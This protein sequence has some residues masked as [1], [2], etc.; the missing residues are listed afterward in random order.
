MA[1]I[2]FRAAPGEAAFPPAETAP[3]DLPD[4][5]HLPRL[6]DT[7]VSARAAVAAVAAVRATEAPFHAYAALAPA[8]R[9]RIARSPE[10]WTWIAGLLEAANELAIDRCPNEGTQGERPALTRAR[11]GASLLKPQEFP[12]SEAGEAAARD[13]AAEACPGTAPPRPGTYPLWA[14]RAWQARVAAAPEDLS[15]WRRYASFLSSTGQPRK[16]AA[17]LALS[18]NVRDPS[19]HRKDTPGQVSVE[20]VNHRHS[21]AGLP[22]TPGCA[23]NPPARAGLD[24]GSRQ[25]VTEA[26]SRDG[27]NGQHPAPAPADRGPRP[28]SLLPSV[29]E[30]LPDWSGITVIVPVYGDARSLKACLGAL[31]ETE[32]GRDWRVLLIDDASPDPEI[33]ACLDTHARNDR[34]H[35]RRLRENR[36]YIGA[37]AAALDLVPVGDV[38]LLNSDCVVPGGDWIDRLAAHAVQGVGTVTPL[39]SNGQGLGFPI[40]FRAAP[41]FVGDRLER[42][43]A[44]ARAVNAGRATPMLTSVGFCT[45]VTRACLSATGGLDTT[46][47]IAGY[48]EEVDFCLRAAA[49]GFR[50]LAATDCFVTHLGS[51]SFRAAKRRLVRANEAI[52]DRRFPTY[53]ARFDAQCAADPLR[54]ARARIEQK[55]LARDSRKG[56]L[57]LVGRD[58]EAL[59]ATRTAWAALQK[60]EPLRLL[61]IEA[62]EAPAA[63]ARLTSPGL[64]WPQNLSYRLPADADLLAADLAAMGHPSLVVA[65]DLAPRAAEWLGNGTFE[66]GHE[67]ETDPP[68]LPPEIREGFD[69]EGYAGLYL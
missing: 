50:H 30:P 57:L 48:G 14:E 53:F 31:E 6:A 42:I 56:G 26:I 67:A 25:P 41:A 13:R 7:E 2:H 64:L 27:G 10:G 68:L 35:I 15:A 34:L 69:T 37:V 29:L 38:I 32:A 17:L 40:P 59:K 1:R 24:R 44:A 47:L 63:T 19:A 52:L 3:P 4:S 20:P 61:A 36:G 12:A 9:R 65:P 16:R 5:L 39:S 8:M 46:G 45:Y 22:S 66:I 33:R 11:D 28:H 54:P 62:L 51:A 18:G 55:L 43:D 60:G 21:P 58:P 49:E 23:Q